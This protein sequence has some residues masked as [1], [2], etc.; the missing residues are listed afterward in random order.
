[1]AVYK[2]HSDAEAAIKEL[3]HSGFDMEKL[4]IVGRDDHT[5]EDLVGYYNAGGRMKYWGRIG[6]FW[7]WT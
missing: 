7:G 2:S 5:E 6:A 3:Q 1:M 4:S